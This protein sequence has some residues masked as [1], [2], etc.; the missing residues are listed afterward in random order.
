MHES[1]VVPDAITV[2]SLL[3]NWA[4]DQDKWIRHLVS[5]VIASGKPTNNAQLDRRCAK[6]FFERERSALAAQ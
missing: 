4:N 5:D 3:V 6:H 2:R 1:S